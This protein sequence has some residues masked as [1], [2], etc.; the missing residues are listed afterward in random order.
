MKSLTLGILGGGRFGR[1]ILDLVQSCAEY[2]K[3]VF[4]DDTIPPDGKQFLGTFSDI[5]A[6]LAKGKVDHLAI[7]IGYKHFELRD[8]LFERYSKTA[9][10]P[11]FVH[12]TAY[13]SKDAEISA[14]CC[15]FSMA[16]VEMEAKLAP[17]VSVFNQTSVTHG[18]HIGAHSFL[19]VGVALTGGV[20]IGSHTFIGANATVTNDLT[21]GNNCLICAGT[22]LTESIP[23]NT[24]VIGNPFKIVNRVNFK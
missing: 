1:L 11:S 2:Q 3:I 4:F 6:A 14:G 7:A 8:S 21:I 19:S 17:N 18:A 22:L 5:D 12:P 16:N 10:F 13:V 20:T 24:C 9:M 15:I 23:D